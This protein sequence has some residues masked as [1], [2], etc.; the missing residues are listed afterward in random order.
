MKIKVLLSI[1]VL[2]FTLSVGCTKATKPTPAPSTKQNQNQGSKPDGV[3][4]ASVVDNAAAFEKAIGTNGTWIIA[5]TKDLTINK[6]LVLE[7]EYKNGKKDKD[8]K[9]VIQR[10]VALYTQDEKRNITARFTLTAPKFTINSPKA[11]IQHGT[12]K[13]D[14]YVSSK[15]FQLIDT[16]VEG[17]VYFTND[18]AKSTFKMDD[19]SSVTGKK[20]VKK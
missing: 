16:K 13:G 20:E 2:S 11:S 7:G 8:G 17:N 18:E 5:I 1:L 12:F 15:D 19:K 3:T 6:D 10:K 4:T 9:D 14:L